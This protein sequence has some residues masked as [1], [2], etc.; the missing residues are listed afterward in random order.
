MQRSAQ[1]KDLRMPDIKF[2]DGIHWIKIDFDFEKLKNQA[3]IIKNLLSHISK[4]RHSCSELLHSP[5]I[6]AFIEDEYIREDLLRIVRQRNPVYY[7]RVIRA[8]FGQTTD[9]HT[10]FTY[11]FNATTNILNKTF[12]IYSTMLKQHAMKVFARH[13]ALD[14]N[15]P[16]IVPKTTIV[17]KLYSLRK[18]AEFIDQNGDVIQMAYDL[19]VPFARALSQS[20]ES[21]I[22]YPLR[23]FTIMNVFRNNPAGGSPRYFQECDYDIVYHGGEGSLIPEAEGIII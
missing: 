20:T 5:L 7:S 10:D 2:P 4:E 22:T 6:P 19:T 3:H 9:I 11:D 15:T 17:D 16:V 12:N 23:R 1:L 13:G 21:D 14:V 18:P 8:L